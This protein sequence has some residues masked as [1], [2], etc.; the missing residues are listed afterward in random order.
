MHQTGNLIHQNT[1]HI[2]GKTGQGKAL[3]QQTNQSSQIRQCLPDV[4]SCPT[5]Q[6]GTPLKYNKSL[7]VVALHSR[8][9][10][11]ALHG[12]P[13]KWTPTWKDSNA[14]H[15]HLDGFFMFIRVRF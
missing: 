4:D 3:F 5:L 6:T 8:N 10:M 15:T 12:T 13:T 14:A 2:H 1:R 9:V 7:F 11:L